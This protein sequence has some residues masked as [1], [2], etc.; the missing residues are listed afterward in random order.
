M[1]DEEKSFVFNNALLFLETEKSIDKI[2]Q[3]IEYNL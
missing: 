1:D 3:E 2:I